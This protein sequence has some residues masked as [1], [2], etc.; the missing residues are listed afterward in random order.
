MIYVIVKGNEENKLE[1]I[2]QHAVWALHFRRRLKHPSVFDVVIHGKPADAY[3]K[4]NIENEVYEKPL[5]LRIK[6]IVT[7]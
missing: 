6:I 5:T 2:K 4:T 3:N 7:E 1:L